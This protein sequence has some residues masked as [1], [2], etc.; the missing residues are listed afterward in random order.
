[1]NSFVVKWPDGILYKYAQVHMIII[2]YMS[3]YEYVLTFTCAYVHVLIHYHPQCLQFMFVRT[4]HYVLAVRFNQ[5]LASRSYSH[6]AVVFNEYSKVY[7]CIHV[8]YVCTV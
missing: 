7:S 4:C 2:V 8:Q 5:I 1:M 6:L 3:L